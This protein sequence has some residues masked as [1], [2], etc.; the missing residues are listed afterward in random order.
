MLPE[1]S[2]EMCSMSNLYEVFHGTGGDQNNKGIGSKRREH[3]REWYLTKLNIAPLLI[4]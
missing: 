4:E 3:Q 1:Y 2:A